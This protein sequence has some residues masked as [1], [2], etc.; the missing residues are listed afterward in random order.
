MIKK[1]QSAH[2]GISLRDNSELT[3]MSNAVKAFDYIACGTPVISSPETELD[4]HL[5][6]TGLY[7]SFPFNDFY[8]LNKFLNNITGS[9]SAYRIAFPNSGKPLNM[10]NR[11]TLTD[12]FFNSI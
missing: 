3:K 12:N 8:N 5:S 9:E 2:L 11:R 4:E 7:K 10:F 6:N 1:I